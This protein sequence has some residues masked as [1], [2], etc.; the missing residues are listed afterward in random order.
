M[1]NSAAKRM[2]LPF[3]PEKNREPFG[4]EVELASVF[5]VAEFER[6]KGKGI[7]L[8]QPNEK[9]QFISQVA[10]PLWLY[11]KNEVTY[12]F[13]ALNPTSNLTL[14]V[15][16][17]PSAKT[18]FEILDN[19][20]KTRQDYT[21]FLLDHLS[22]FDQPKKEKQ[23]QIEGLIANEE[24]K[25]EFAL[26][27]KEAV[28]ITQQNQGLLTPDLSESEILTSLN[29]L[30]KL[31]NEFREDADKLSEC[32]RLINRLTSQYVTE[33]DYAAQAVKDESTAKIKAQEELINPQIAKLNSDYK[34]RIATITKGYDEE[35]EHLEKQKAKTK[36]AIESSDE[37]IDL[38]QREA[39]SQARQNHLAYEKRWKNK[40]AKTKKE[41]EGLKKQ[42]SKLE[43]SISNLKKQKTDEVNRLGIK[44]EAE[45]KVI[46]QP[47]LDLQTV[48]DAKMLVFK[49]Q[50]DQL[51]K[52]EKTVTEPVYRAI[53]ERET[54][55]SMF[56]NLGMKEAPL[57]ISMLFYVPFYVV[58]YSADLSRR[59]V[60]LPPSK[61]SVIGLSGKLKGA[62][63]MSKIKEKF[64]PR[65]KA[66]TELIERCQVLIRQDTA[67]ETEIDV[68]GEKNNFLNKTI[69]LENI[70]KGLVYLQHE[71]TL[72]DKEYQSLSWSLKK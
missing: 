51:V 26:Y 66:I 31:L 13:D 39:Q 20:S 1:L 63:G 42:F 35:V 59:Y 38:Y 25:K 43:K 4:Y 49:Q 2:I 65:F 7:V 54:L 27:R 37:K 28:E 24:F 46:R 22:Y 40:V 47:L 58:C 50:I 12:I 32:L 3:S 53:K 34:K 56:E 21:A 41:V 9:L 29:E 67:F 60:F 44:F 18:F 62:F 6:S 11:P 57:K 36:K 5:A 16:Q 72:S 70:A 71:G 55:N 8:R 15:P 33:L 23:I 52:L 14:Q 45:I 10:Y 48:L 19:Q 64:T 17:F 69:D 61:N 68:F 30:E